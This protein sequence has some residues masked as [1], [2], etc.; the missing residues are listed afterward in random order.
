VDRGTRLT[1]A[2]PNQHDSILGR[3]K[4]TTN[5]INPIPTAPEKVGNVQLIM[6]PPLSRTRP[7]R[8]SLSN[9]LYHTWVSSAR[10]VSSLF[11][12]NDDDKS[13]KCPECYSARPI[14]D[15]ASY[16]A[17]LR[18][19]IHLGNPPRYE[20]CS[21]CNVVIACPGD[22]LDCNIC[23]SHRT[24][25]LEYIL[26]ERLTPWTAPEATIVGISTTRL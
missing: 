12:E 21:A 4:I 20:R 9:V 17:V 13:I 26:A 7:D 15:Q 19:Y 24:E 25:F 14:T 10:C 23:L 11:L 8:F 18:H 16:T 6:C 3:R 2:P 1:A 5:P 22:I